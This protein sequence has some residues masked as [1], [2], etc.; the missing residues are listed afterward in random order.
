MDS[1]PFAYNIFPRLEVDLM[2]EKLRFKFLNPKNL[3]FNIF[4]SPKNMEKL[5]YG[6]LKS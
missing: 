5:S 1:A 6:P 2:T 4:V 3:N